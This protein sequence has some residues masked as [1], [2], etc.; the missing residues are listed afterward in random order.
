MNKAIDILIEKKYKN[1]L[2]IFRVYWDIASYQRKI[3]DFE[4]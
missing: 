1:S 4:S 3:E 2:H